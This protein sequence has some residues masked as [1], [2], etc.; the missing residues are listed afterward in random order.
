MMYRCWDEIII[1]WIHYRVGDR[2]LVWIYESND[3]VFNV[4]WI[5]DK[6][7][8][9]WTSKHDWIFPVHRDLEHL[10]ETIQ[11]LLNYRVWDISNVF[12]KSLMYGDV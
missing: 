1:H 6:Y 2:Y 8:F 10:N 12:Y 4:L 3:E 9:C 11:N 7:G 5:K